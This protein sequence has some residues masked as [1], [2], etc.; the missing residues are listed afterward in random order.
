M[1]KASWPETTNEPVESREALAPRYIAHMFKRQA[2]MAD[3][4]CH[5]YREHFWIPTTE[6]LADGT[7]LNTTRP[8]RHSG[9]GQPSQ[10]FKFCKSV[11]DR[12]PVF[13]EC[14]EYI[15]RIPRT[16]RYG[17]WA[18]RSYGLRNK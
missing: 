16:E 15:Q 9:H 8:P 13:Q 10:E 14:E 4:L 1:G 11:C 7:V 6:T 12:C 18:G 2:W 17:F 3:A 5:E